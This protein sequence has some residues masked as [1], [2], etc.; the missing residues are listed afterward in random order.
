M[1]PTCCDDD[2]HDKVDRCDNHRLFST[3]SSISASIPLP[4]EPLANETDQE[5]VQKSIRLY[6]EIEMLVA[7]RDK[8]DNGDYP[9][10]FVEKALLESFLIHARALRDFLYKSRS[11]KSHGKS[12]CTR[13]ARRD[14]IIAEDFFDDPGDWTKVL[15]EKG[16][17]KS[18]S[19]KMRREVGKE[20]AHLTE[21]R[22]GG[23]STDW[24][25][26]K[27]CEDLI[28]LLWLFVTKV[29]ASRIDRRVFSL[30]QRQL[31]H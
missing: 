15:D 5:L 14:D 7:C 3:S 29:P 8:L 24:D 17:P 31:S 22:L 10:E 20:I 6:Y 30:L 16:E 13:P 28:Q 27:I 26:I 11:K 18:L 21:Y 12:R 19:Y 2:V 1:K 9:D 23:S 4:L 25:V